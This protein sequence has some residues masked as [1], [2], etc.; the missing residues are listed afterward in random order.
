MKPAFRLFL[1]GK[2]FPKLKIR[3][4]FPARVPFVLPIPKR[5]EYPAICVHY[6]SSKTAK[7]TFRWVTIAD[8]IMDRLAGNAQRIDLKETP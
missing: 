8:A 2:Q 1:P 4:E 3:S 7:A 5:K 6:N